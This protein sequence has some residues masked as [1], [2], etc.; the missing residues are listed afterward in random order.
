MDINLSIDHDEVSTII[1]DFIKTYVFNSGCK[2]VV[3]GL[4][5]GVDSAVVAQLCKDALGKKNTRCIFLPN[6]TTPKLDFKHLD[7]IVKKLDLL[8]EK[9]DITDIVNGINKNCIIK[10]D[11]F[12]QANIKARTRMLLLFEYANMT[13]CL[14]CGTSNKSELLVGY[15]TKYGD[16]GVDFQPIGDLYK[17]QVWEMAKYLK[18]LKAIISKP[19]TA[20]LWSGQ[21]DEEELKISYKNLDFILA[22]LEQKMDFNEIA[23]LAG[24]KTSD[25]KRIHKMRVIS[26][27]KR[28]TPLIPKIGL[29]TVGIDWRSPVQKG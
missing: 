22:G 23:K 18:I 24:V 28:R 10:P 2:G 19:P 9:K 3:I 6:D 12:A 16:G 29:R 7:L 15:F 1:K 26:Q 4:S 20:G 25:V 8:C 13:N 21:T 11:K 5:G 14:V 17:T 27:H